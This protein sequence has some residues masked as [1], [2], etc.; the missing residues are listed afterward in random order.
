M[1]LFKLSDIL[2]SVIQSDCIDAMSKMPD[3]CVDMVLCDLPY[4][5]T[6]NKWDSIIP[7][8]N[9]WEQYKRILKPN[10]V[11]VLTSLGLFTAQLIPNY[12]YSVA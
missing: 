11:V 12:S 1:S 3:K 10:G 7:L 6:Q 2:N 9:L 4:G 8:E 5:T